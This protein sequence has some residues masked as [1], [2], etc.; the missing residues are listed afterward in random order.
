MKSVT[1]KRVG[2]TPR[3]TTLPARR[4]ALVALDRL[5]RGLARYRFPLVL[6]V[7]LGLVAL[8]QLV[9]DLS[10]G[11]LRMVT[12]SRSIPRWTMIGL[13]LYELLMTAVV[14]R[15]VRR[16]LEPLRRVV[17]LDGTA[18]GS[19]EQ[20]MQRRAARTDIVLLLVAAAVV[21]FLFLVVGYELLDDDPLVDQRN[22]LPEA[23]LS[24]FVVL[25][26]YTVVGWAG[27]RL[28][29]VAARLGRLLGR[30]SREPLEVNVFDTTPL[31]P[32][33]NIALAVAFAPAGIIA[34]LLI[35]LGA[36][37]SVLGWTVL[38]LATAAS[39]LALLLPL[40]GVH[41]Q[42][43]QAKDNALATVNDRISGLYEDIS[44]TPAPDAGDLTRFRDTASALIPLRKTVEEMTTW[45]FRDTVAFGRAVL[46]AMAPLIYTT[47]S[48]L[49]KVFYIAPLN[50]P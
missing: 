29:Y 3:G 39:L 22:P 45:P 7:A 28:I 19:Y 32:F 50:R 16:S 34:I 18:F 5:G 25:V 40:R 6:I 10:D 26:G 35:G 15:T 33:G 23:P 9:E 44:R 21:V 47:L 11:T 48:E 13:V 41:R 38:L 12:P 37:G 20:R 4:P 24:A 2:V 17:K 36:P 43:S 8:G 46:I 14:E 1:R 42:M 31:L 49:I 27:L 30:L